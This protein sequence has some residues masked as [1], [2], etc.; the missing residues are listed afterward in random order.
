MPEIELKFELDA[1][2]RRRLVHARVL[3]GNRSKRRPMASLYL[4][5][6]QCELA[7]REMAL[8]LRMRRPAAPKHINPGCDGIEDE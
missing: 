1:Q 6:P 4:D 8:R 3:A 2:A 7:R 5:T